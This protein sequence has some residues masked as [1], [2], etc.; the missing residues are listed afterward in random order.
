MIHREGERRLVPEADVCEVADDSSRRTFTVSFPTAE[1]VWWT[2]EPDVRVDCARLMVMERGTGRG[3]EVAESVGVRG[4]RGGKNS[5]VMPERSR[6]R[7]ELRRE[8]VSSSM[9]VWREEE[10]CRAV[11][12]EDVE[13]DCR[14]AVHEHVADASK[15][16]MK[17]I[18]VRIS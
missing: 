6:W 5:T 16:M 18:R 10:A 17:W 4:S 12:S 14:E 2:A 9:C 8:R 7:E 1:M 13:Q 15:M 11:E 3:E